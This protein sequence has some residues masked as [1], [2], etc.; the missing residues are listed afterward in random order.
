MSRFWGK[1]ENV[2]SVSRL[3][4][5]FRCVVG[6]GC[7][8]A[9]SGPRAWPRLPLPRSAVVRP[10]TSP[11]WGSSACRSRF[12]SC[13]RGRER[14]GAR[15]GRGRPRP[16]P[17]PRPPTSR[18]P[19]TR[20]VGRPIAYRAPRSPARFSLCLWSAAGRAGA[21]DP[22]GAEAWQA[23]SAGPAAAFSPCPR[24]ATTAA[25][26]PCTSWFGTTTTG[27]WRRSCGAR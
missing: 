25:T 19:R 6:S 4:C 9:D 1:G 24:P 21:G 22:A 10:R 14:G 5:V 16:R 3:N 8:R 18:A 26:S 15:G 12:G 11:V 17:G 7:G 23:G 27:S 13:Q 2:S 20:P